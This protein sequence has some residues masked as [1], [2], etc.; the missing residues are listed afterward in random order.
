MELRRYLEILWQNR[1]QFI[2]VVAVTVLSAYLLSRFVSPVYEATTKVTIK[3]N[4]QTSLIS[5]VSRDLGS[6]Q[7]FNKD[8]VVGTIEN[9]LNSEIVLQKLIDDLDLRDSD[10]ELF[11]PAGFVDQNFFSLILSSKKGVDVDYMNDSNSFDIV[12]YSSDP[13]EAR[14]IADG[15]VEAFFHM[16]STKNANEVQSAQKAI[17]K[18]IKDVQQKL[19][20]AEEEQRQ[21][22]FKENIVDVDEQIST[23]IDALSSL[24]TLRLSSQR[25]LKEAYSELE[26]FN[27]V[28]RR[29]IDSQDS[30]I[31]ISD[32]DSFTENKSRLLSLEVTLLGLMTELKEDHPEVVETRARI[33]FVKENIRREIISKL[34]IKTYE[35]Y[36]RLVTEQINKQI[37][38]IVLKS[39]ENIVADQIIEL[40]KRIFAMKEDQTKLVSFGAKIS[41]LRQRYSTL[42]YDMEIVS[43]A[44][45]LEL[46]N[47]EIV[48]PAFVADNIDFNRYFPKS[49]KKTFVLAFIIGVFT[50]TFLVFFLN[51]VDDTLSSEGDIVNA[52]KQQALGVIPI[53]SKRQLNISSLG[54]DMRLT[55]S[56]LDLRSRLDLSSA[57]GDKKVLSI[58]SHRER[59][60]KS[61][62]SAFLAS[63]IARAG[64]KVLLI[65]ANLRKPF[66]GGFMNISADNGLSDFLE[67]KVDIFETI[68]SSSQENLDVISSGRSQQDSLKTI[69][70]EKVA[71][72][73]NEVTPK[74]DYIIIDNL[75]LQ[76]GNDAVEVSSKAD[77]VIFLAAS[78]KT[79]RENAHHSIGLLKDM[80]CKVIGVVL[81]KVSNSLL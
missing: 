31:L 70:S 59:D 45:L 77:G 53:F 76:E 55:N 48:Q 65:D 69:N 51:Y 27:D 61:V 41:N 22:M 3:L 80:G 16:E 79:T 28:L 54:V 1:K 8:F 26:T 60:G 43:M 18:N 81:N 68:Y 56:F 50:A 25:S 21:Y 47:L 33:N 58:V 12:G 52:F 75:A 10:D 44:E 4:P 15:L 72:L 67:G 34:D 36:G 78:G 73:L 32:N 64:Q 20:I 9:N 7:Y 13:E 35:Y 5:Q 39:R 30:E 57:D 6:F 11:D 71:S 14:M 23:L 66:I 2:L 62:V 17:E 37:D 49:T 63:T 40:N 38:I 29:E 74:Y 42:L 19:K 46:S 24:E